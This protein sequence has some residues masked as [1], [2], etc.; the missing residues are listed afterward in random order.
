MDSTLFCRVA[1]GGSEG[2]RKALRFL[3]RGYR[4][5]LQVQSKELS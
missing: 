5:E 4:L 2:D 3:V 1:E